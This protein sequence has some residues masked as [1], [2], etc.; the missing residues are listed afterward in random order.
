MVIF[1]KRSGGCMKMVV[2]MEEHE[3]VPSINQLMLEY[4]EFFEDEDLDEG[5]DEFE[6]YSTLD[7]LLEENPQY[8]E[9]EE[10]V[11]V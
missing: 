8:F 3:E 2:K 1:L 9:E 4:P 10:E 5:I 6:E 11:N 7:E